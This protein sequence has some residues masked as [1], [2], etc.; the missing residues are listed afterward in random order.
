MKEDIVKFETDYGKNSYRNFL[1]REICK[2]IRHEFYHW[3]F[4]RKLGTESEIS[5]TY[6]SISKNNLINSRVDGLTYSME[7]RNITIGYFFREFIQF[8]YDII[9]CIPKLKVFNIFYKILNFIGTFS[10]KIVRLKNKLQNINLIKKKLKL[11][12][13]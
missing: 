12:W 1:I 10:Y 4:Y 9:S 7:E 3:I 2:A 13:I 11:K 8:I 5:I 6:L